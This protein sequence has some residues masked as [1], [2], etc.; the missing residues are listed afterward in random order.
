MPLEA[1]AGGCTDQPSHA[2][3]AL[4][5]YQDELN[6]GKI[7]IPFLCASAPCLKRESILFVG[8]DIIKSNINSCRAHGSKSCPK[9]TCRHFCGD[10]NKAIEAFRL[11][12]IWIESTA[13][14]SKAV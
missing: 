3:L 12:S 13:V 8:A 14:L 9:K 2:V 4:E 7:H 1:A 5:V 10:N 11:L 6:A